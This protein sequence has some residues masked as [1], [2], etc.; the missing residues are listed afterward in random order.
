M[1]N[2][3]AHKHDKMINNQGRKLCAWLCLHV[4]PVSH[5]VAVSVQDTASQLT[6]QLPIYNSVT[7]CI[8]YMFRAMTL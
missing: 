6:D 3:Q 4:K 7:K 8:V 5:S 2:N 1:I